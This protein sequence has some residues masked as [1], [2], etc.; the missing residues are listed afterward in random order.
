ME[1]SRYENPDLL[2]LLLGLVP[3]VAYYIYRLK[4]GRAAI[5]FSSIEPFKHVK[6]I[7]WY[8]RHIPFVLRLA[9]IALLI[10][11]AARPQSATQHQNQN[12]EGIDIMLALDIS[13]SMLARDFKPDR[14]TAAKDILSKFIIDRPTDRIGLVVFAGEAFTQ[15]PLTTDHRTLVNM[16]HQVQMGMINDGTAIGNGLATAVN[17]L[18][19]STAPSKVIILL[20]D[21]V[22]NTGQID[23]GTASYIAKDEGIKLY[24]I[25]VG[26]EGTAP[27][28][29]YDAWGDVVFQ[30]MK[31]EIDEELLESIAN[32]TGGQYFRATDNTKLSEIYAEI[33]KLETVEVEIE[34]FTRYNDIFHQ[35]LLAALLLLL[36]EISCKYFVFR[37]LP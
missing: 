15:V 35:F 37:Q 7:R 21:G 20:T 4:S 34:N 25:G 32:E 2:W 29:A 5:F 3:L 27:Y 36:C 23:P 13:S 33:N 28:P 24:T 1:I 26:S 31:V 14:L 17:R 8:L 6:T 16:L 9:V 22:N 10:F 12:S 18:K 30:D 11:V 19:E